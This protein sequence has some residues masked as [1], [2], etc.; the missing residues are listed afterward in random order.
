[1][2][3]ANTLRNELLA[4]IMSCISTE[5]VVRETREFFT[6]CGL[7]EEFDVACTVTPHDGNASLRETQHHF[8]VLGYALI[9]R[10]TLF[11]DRYN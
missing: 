7:A 1:M 6:S 3:L 9:G 5:D 4:I 11:V 10:Y 2:A 8:T